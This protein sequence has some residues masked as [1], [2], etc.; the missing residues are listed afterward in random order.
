MIKVSN[1][2]KKFESKIA[3]NDLS[4]QIQ[5]GVVTGF[6]G[7]NGAG[8]TTTMRMILG[9]ISPN[10]GKIF[11]DGKAYAD[12][13]NPLKDIGAMVYPAVADTQFTPRQHL[14]ILATASNIE[15]KKVDQILS[16]VGLKE[17]SNK[18][19]SE[20]S[21]GMKQRVHIASALLGNP[22]TIMMDEPFNGLDVEGIHW[23]RTLLKDLANQG[24]AVLISSHLL[25]EVEEVADRVIVLA[26][27][28]LIADIELQQKSLSSFVQVQSDNTSKLSKLLVEKGADVMLSEQNILH[29]TLLNAKQIGDIAFTNGISI[30]ELSIHQPT[31]EQLFSELVEGKTEYNG[32]T[33]NVESEEI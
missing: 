17:A 32:L 9:L 12:L 28:E 18:K 29:V 4:F 14:T 15:T 3:V 13:K 22:E 31:L 23:L 11:I 7:P 10:F 27:G 20:F 2:T 26:E 25:S 8:K 19:I 24:K 21:F 16:F 1:I 33:S 6:L 5:R 30:Y